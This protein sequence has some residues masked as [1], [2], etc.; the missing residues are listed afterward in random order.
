[1]TIHWCYRWS[2]CTCMP[3]LVLWLRHASGIHGRIQC[4]PCW[5]MFCT[6]SRVFPIKDLHIVRV[7][8]WTAG[9]ASSFEALNFLQLISHHSCS[10]SGCL[11]LFGLFSLQISI[12]QFYFSDLL[13]Y[14]N[15]LTF[16][17]S[18]IF[19]YSS[20]MFCFI[21]SNLLVYLNGS[22]F[23]LSSVFLYSSEMFCFSSNFS[24]DSFRCFWVWF[25]KVVY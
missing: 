8:R 12:L 1:M 25:H 9:K 2:V 15:G 14:L 13:V 10:E 7:I 5:C 4:L 17:L 21:F 24:S 20:L 16:P 6:C 23:L 18:S 22:T 11:N 19:F 3:D